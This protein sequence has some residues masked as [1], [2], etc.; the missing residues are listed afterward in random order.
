MSC[1]SSCQ[2]LV[3]SCLARSRQEQEKNTELLIVILDK[4]HCRKLPIWC[5]IQMAL[6]IHFFFSLRKQLAEYFHR[7]L[8]NNLLWKHGVYVKEIVYMLE[9]T[10]HNLK[11]LF[12]NLL[13]LS[14][15]YVKSTFCIKRLYR[16]RRCPIWEAMGAIFKWGVFIKRFAIHIVQCV[17]AYIHMLFLNYDYN[18]LPAVFQI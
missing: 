6:K 9:R 13:C 17:T 5:F 4:F 10:A 11:P 16:Y 18:Y 15:W 3:V 2:L 7:I 14:V 1:N 8:L 12:K